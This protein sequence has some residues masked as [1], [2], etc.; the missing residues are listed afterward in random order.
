MGNPLERGIIV[1]PRIYIR[2]TKVDIPNTSL[3]SSDL[4][5]YLLYWDKIDYPQ[6]T[7]LEFG[8][9]PDEEF[10]LS[11][12]VL[13]QTK[14]NALGNVSD[15]LIKR[16]FLAM[17]AHERFEPGQWSLAQTTDILQGASGLSDT[18]RAL[19]VEL[20]HALPTPPDSVSL[21]DI[22]T[23]KDVRRGEILALRSAFDGMQRDIEDAQDVPRAKTVALQRLETSLSDL[24]RVASQAWGTRVVQSLK[25]DLNL[26]SMSGI[27]SLGAIAATSIGIDPLAGLAIG[28]A[29]SCI[30]FDAPL[31]PRPKSSLD[32]YG[33]FAYVKSISNDLS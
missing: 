22:L 5:F 21:E 12:G 15:M 24:N 11:A 16:Q 4:R 26:Q 33:P 8:L 6:L 20:Y 17:E 7:V 25:I 18:S 29:A 30:K 9:R 14:V 13:T 3:E 31:V 32:R 27:G 2:G 23:F 19:E 10:L 1:G 28:S